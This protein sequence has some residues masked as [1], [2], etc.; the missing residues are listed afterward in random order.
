MKSSS[1][2]LK[3]FVFIGLSTL[4]FACTKPANKSQLPKPV[5][6]AGTAKLS[7]KIE[8]YKIDSTAFTITV[9]L[10]ITL[11]LARQELKIESDGS[12]SIEVPI[13]TNP[14]IGFLYDS[15][16]DKGFT[17]S[18]EAD[19]ETRILINNNSISVVSGPDFYTEYNKRTQEAMIKAAQLG[20]KYD[21]INIELLDSCIENPN[22]YI[23]INRYDLDKS[24]DVFRKDSLLSEQSK[25]Y[26]SYYLK[27]FH[28]ASPLQFTEGMDILS[29]DMRE[30]DDTT[31]IKV[32]E[33]DSLYYTFMK[34]YDLGNPYYLYS[35][36]YGRIFQTILRN[37]TFNIPE[38]KETPV[39]EWLAGV[40]HTMADL[41]GTDTGLFY[42]MIIG[43][44]YMRQ[45]SYQMS[46]FS[47][48]QIQNIKEYF[49]NAELAKII[50]QKNE[51]VVKIAVNKEETQIH[52]TPD[53]AKEKLM[54][55]I[56][57]KYKGKVV[58]VDFWAT[59]CGPCL[60]AMKEMGPLKQEL[61]GKGIIFVYITDTSS[62]L[63]LWEERTNSIDGEHYYLSA[64]EW[65][66]ISDNLNIDGI[67]AYLL[68]DKSGVIKYK[69]IGYPGTEKFKEKIEEL[70]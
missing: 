46:P 27:S 62:P 5:I 21:L 69:T 2:F 52:K 20:A 17:V 4:L 50:L 25:I 9:P 39:K 11:D 36:V 53:V 54:E 32:K 43:Q 33:P 38:I 65:G 30:K 37:E 45:L 22:R 35:E 13:E 26:L 61:K 34:E 23:P 70:L 12:F 24:L 68:Y 47:D 66:Y 15:N 51:E 57:D 59:W 19:K 63:K 44:S 8:G 28:I 55:T 18:L 49:G 3:L 14:A 64:E 29:R 6:E 7:G 31:T 67:P 10:P 58:L 60:N 40:K 42:D 56:I 1:L 41:V 48:K 16:S